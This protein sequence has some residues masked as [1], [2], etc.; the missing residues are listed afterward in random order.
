MLPRSVRDGHSGILCDCGCDCGWLV[1]VHVLVPLRLLRAGVEHL[2]PG[3]GPVLGGDDAE[4]AAAGT[5][6]GLPAGQPVDSALRRVDGTGQ[7][8]AVAAVAHD[9]HAEGRLHVLEGA[10]LLQVHGVPADLDKR[11]PAAVHVRAGHVGGPV[12]ARVRRVPPA[13]RVRDG[14]SG[15]VDVVVRSGAR[16]V[17]CAGNRQR[18]LPAAARHQRRDQHLLVARQHRLAERHA[19]AGARVRSDHGALARVAVVLARERRP[20]RPVLLA[21]QPAV[22]RPWVAVARHLRVPLAHQLAGLAGV[23]APLARAARLVVVH[24][25]PAVGPGLLHG[26]HPL[27]VREGASQAAAAAAAAPLVVLLVHVMAGRTAARLVHIAGRAHNNTPHA[28]T[29]DYHSTK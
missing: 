24:R 2:D 19:A 1:H 15:R 5:G 4:R 23:G 26:H 20:Q 6:R 3:F 8:L 17:F 28:N 9:P 10:R 21:V 22:L 25:P 14:N 11:V 12:P 7:P 27:V 13:A 16:P 29:A 18:L